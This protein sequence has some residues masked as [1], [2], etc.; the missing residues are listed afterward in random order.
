M[1]SVSIGGSGADR[2]A[3][4]HPENGAGAL[5]PVGSA[6]PVTYGPFL[7]NAHFFGIAAVGRSDRGGRHP[8]SALVAEDTPIIP[9]F[10]PA[11][12]CFKTGF[13]GNAGPGD[14]H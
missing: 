14:Q 5:G 8:I 4:R 9:M 2:R 1:I 7:T 13:P 6:I 10:R 12:L 3:D 11:Y